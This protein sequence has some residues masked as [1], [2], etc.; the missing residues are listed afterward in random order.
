MII[1]V[2]E[3]KLVNR[4]VNP[5]HNHKWIRIKSLENSKKITSR[6]CLLEIYRSRPQ[7]MIFSSILVDKVKSN[8]LR[9]VRINKLIYRKEQLLSNST[10][11][12]F[13]KSLFSTVELTRCFY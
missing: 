13:Q 11:R 7:K 12:R 2:R 5:K 8:S 9:S 6:R 3:I 10:I 4:Q 1:K